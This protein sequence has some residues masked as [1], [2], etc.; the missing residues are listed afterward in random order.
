MP[1]N[2]P[3]RW[4]VTPQRRG[5]RARIRSNWQVRIVVLLAVAG[6]LFL[7]VPLVVA[8][9]RFVHRLNAD[10]PLERL[11]RAAQPSSAK[12]FDSGIRSDDLDS[13]G[14]AFGITPDTPADVL[15]LRPAGWAPR[16]GNNRDADSRAYR[17]EGLLLTVQAERCG[18]R[19]CHPGDTLVCTEVINVA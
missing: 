1:V 5:W 7:I 2:R 9:F 4:D 17:R 14:F 3:L 6:T 19:K 18:L 12:I 11:A 10:R 15:S 8:G 16:P 13:N